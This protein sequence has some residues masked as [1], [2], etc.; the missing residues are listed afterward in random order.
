MANQIIFRLLLG[1]FLFNFAYQ[2][3][4]QV[5]I[6]MD[7][8]TPDPSAILDIKDT[9][10]GLLVPRLTLVQRR[11]LATNTER[12]AAHSLVV[13]DHESNM[14]YFW[15]LGTRTWNSINP[16]TLA[17]NMDGDLSNDH[18][19]FAG[20][21]NVGIGVGLTIPSSKL[22]VKGTTTTTNLF[23]NQ[24]R[25]IG[26]TG[27]ELYN[28]S[29]KG[30]FINN[31][32]NVGI[33]DNTPN[34]VLDIGGNLDITGD[35]KIK[36]KIIFS[37][38][39]NNLLIGEN[40]GILLEG[41][42]WDRNTI[43]G[44][45]AASKMTKGIGNI[46]LG[47]NAAQNSVENLHG[48]VFIGNE[49]GRDVNGSSGSLSVANIYIGSESGS[50]CSGGSS[51][52]FIGHGAAKLRAQ[53]GSGNVFLGYSAG[54]H[55]SGDYNILIGDQAGGNMNDG[56]ANIFIGS[57]AGLGAAGNENIC[58]GKFTGFVT[59]GNNNILIGN[60]V[61]VGARSN[62]INIGGVILGETSP[63][64]KI[65]IF[66]D[67][68]VTGACPKCTSDSTL[69]Y[70]VN[71]VMLGSLDK[72]TRLNG[73]T[74]LWKQDTEQY[75]NQKD[76]QIGL[77]AQ[78]VQREFPLL[79]HEAQAGHLYIDYQKMVV[80]LLEAVKELKAEQDKLNAELDE[81]EK[82]LRELEAM[83]SMLDQKD[84]HMQEMEARLDKLEQLIQPKN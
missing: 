43:I 59:N 15:N 26:N 70:N 14:F 12:S 7:D 27:L 4:G 80:P 37:T 39:K 58:I 38:A 50:N 30:L 13:F 35:Y 47:L 68:D 73:Y 18:L 72:I 61:D 57:G 64:N 62:Q 53:G 31:G 24:V 9:E 77:M 63:T 3:I 48:N 2:A 28:I 84:R 74:Y 19:V 36:N 23:T 45:G 25:A 69:K 32:G 54:A 11:N 51:N 22:E 42:V 16:W 67:F 10:R 76:L 44:H 82:R 8:A 52:V 75:K 1:F 79:V 60:S 49:A 41:G 29:G 66:G 83:Q 65:T 6:S 71:P 20:V 40:A 78:E 56:S 21:G 55:G 33:N 34:D 17:D 81:K 5:G 46:I